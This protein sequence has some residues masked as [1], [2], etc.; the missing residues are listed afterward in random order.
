MKGEIKMENKDRTIYVKDTDNAAS[1][2]K[3][4]HNKA[5]GCF[6]GTLFLCAVPSNRCYRLC[7]FEDNRFDM[8]S[9]DKEGYDFL[10]EQQTIDEL[11]VSVTNILKEDL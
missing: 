4:I 1:I 9:E 6:W 2:A 11:A 7:Q 5:D 8:H 10:A 3:A